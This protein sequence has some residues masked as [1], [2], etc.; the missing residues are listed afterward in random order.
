MDKNKFVILMTN[1]GKAF[2]QKIDKETMAVYYEFLKDIDEETLKE[3]CKNIIKN[4]KYFPTVSEIVAESETHNKETKFYI[5]EFMKSQ[6]YFKESDYGMS[7]YEKACHW[8]TTGVVPGWLKEDM[9][10]YAKMYKQEQLK[11][12]EQ[13]RLS[14]E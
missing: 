10:E 8:L 4:N 14:Y 11:T 6:G 12:E 9:E 5:L 2:R 13:K 7:E 3:A 1:L